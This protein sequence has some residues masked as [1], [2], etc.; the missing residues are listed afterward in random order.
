MVH[1]HRWM[2]VLPSPDTPYMFLLSTQV[3]AE[4]IA[5]GVVVFGAAHL[6]ARVVSSLEQFQGIVVDNSA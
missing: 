1:C 6:D 4:T 5:K 3:L 2:L